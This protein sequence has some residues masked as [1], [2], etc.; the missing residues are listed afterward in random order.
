MTEYKDYLGRPLKVG[1]FVVAAGNRGWF[2]KGVVV[3]YT[4]TMVRT[5][6]GLY[7][8]GQLMISTEQFHASGHSEWMQQTH[9]QYKDKLD[10]SKPIEKPKQTWKYLISIVQDRDTKARF[11]VVMKLN[12][13][14][15]ELFNDSRQVWLKDRNYFDG[16][17]AH[18]LRKIRNPV[19]SYSSGSK[20]QQYIDGFDTNYSWYSGKGET[21]STVKVHGMETLI[22]SP[23]P[24]DQFITSFP[25]FNLAELRSNG[26]I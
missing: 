5:S 1:D 21:L 2:D 10:P 3:G 19:W 18:Y 14:S 6:C 11:G 9:D 15:Q 8:A 16:D 26:K 23:M 25:K 22:N 7:G 12:G 4:P 20:I 24:I 17:K 13:N